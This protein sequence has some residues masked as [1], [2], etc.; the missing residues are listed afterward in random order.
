MPN[1]DVFTDEDKQMVLEALETAKVLRQEI[2]RAKRAGLDVTDLEQELNEYEQKLRG[3]E[4]V[5][6]RTG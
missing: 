3:I 4:R 6:V 2:A 5:Y 1:I